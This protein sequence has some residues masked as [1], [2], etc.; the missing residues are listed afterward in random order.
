VARS[1]R[2]KGGTF[3]KKRRKADWVYRNH[4]YIDEAMF[5]P[6]GYGIAED[7]DNVSNV[8]AGARAYI[9][10][11]SQHV[12]RQSSLFDEIGIG[13]AA[14]GLLPASARPEYNRQPTVQ[15][16]DGWFT[17]RTSAWTSGD[18]WQ[19]GVRLGWFE[20]DLD[21]G[22]LSLDVDYGMMDLA[23]SEVFRGP[24]IC[25]NDYATHI[26]DWLFTHQADGGNNVRQLR[27]F[28]TGRRRAP[29]EKHC[30]ALY[31]EGRDIGSYQGPYISP[32]VRALIS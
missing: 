4:I 28:W 8:S 17:T 10:L 20:Q 29:S 27:I 23:L 5:S 22:N 3:R 24:A 18:R 9:L 7:T 25:A 26:R 19:I 31:V 16:V 21:T 12:L 11:D 30:L 6:G 13:V 32:M 15:C 14:A 2:R 1:R